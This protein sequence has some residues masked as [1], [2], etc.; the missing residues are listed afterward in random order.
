[1]IGA[2]KKERQKL[3]RIPASDMRYLTCRY[4][5]CENEIGPIVIALTFQSDRNI[6]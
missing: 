3:H 5:M 6:D 2:F 4:F 1:M